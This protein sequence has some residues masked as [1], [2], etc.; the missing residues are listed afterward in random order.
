MQGSA[1]LNKRNVTY[2]DDDDD[3]QCMWNVKTNVLPA[4]IGVMGT[5]S[6]S[7]R[8]HI[9]NIPGNHKV[10][11]MQKTAILGTAHILRKVTM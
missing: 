9:S 7:F 10:K 2:N 5:I 6:K 4:I 8:K 3:K 1:D 11:E